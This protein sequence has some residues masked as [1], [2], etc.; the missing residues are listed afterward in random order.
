MKNNYLLLII[1]IAVFFRF[2]QLSLVP[3]GLY[4]DEAINANE[5]ATNPGQLFYPNNNGREGLL[6]N[7]INIAFSWLGTSIVSLRSVSALIGV[8]T[9][10]GIYLLAQEMF[11]QERVSLL[12]AF[13]LAVSFW[14]VN[15]SRIAFRGILVPFIL[16]FAFYFLFR[17]FRLKRKSYL[18]ISGFLFGLGFYTYISYRFAVLLLIF[19]L[20]SQ[21]LTSKKEG[22]QKEFLFQA[23]FLLIIIFITALPIGIYFLKNPQDFIGRSAPISIFSAENPFK[24]LVKSFVLHLA[25][26]N[27]AGDWNW[28]HNFSGSPQLFL[29]VG[30]M[31]LI[32]LYLCLKRNEKGYKKYFLVAWLLIMALPGILTYEGVPHAL[33][34]IGTIPAAYILAALGG[35]YIYAQLKKKIDNKRLLTA[36]S[37]LF[38]VFLT[39]Y[40]F[41]KYFI[42]WAGNENVLGA[43]SK[44]LVEIG[45]YLNCLPEN[46][47]KYV[48]VNQAGLAVPLPD[49]LSVSAQTP[50]FIERSRWGHLRTEYLRPDQINEITTENQKTIII[51]M[52]QDLDLLAQLQEKFPQG[53]IQEENQIPIFN[54]PLK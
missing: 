41:N 22:R 49:G 31:F 42:S 9:V 32:G 40:Q 11:Q 25:M 28:R 3:P 1:I 53:K 12:S 8:L 48:I 46:I 50:M 19:T 51:L 7:L 44:D 14:H 6:M 52:Q 33:R 54:I 13:L 26:F 27:I 4:P 21:W 37:C 20:M 18:L 10:I 2:W 29:P 34:V 30:I 16:V 38:L 47:K 5:A 45:N 15:F 23:S 36:I 43:F 39:C 17:S 24:E 35:D